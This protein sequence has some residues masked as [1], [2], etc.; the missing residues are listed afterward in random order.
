VKTVCFALSLI[1]GLAFASSALAQ[2]TKKDADLA[3]LQEAYRGQVSKIEA[4]YAA[5][6]EKIPADYT[7]ALNALE[8]SFTKKGDLD[9]IVAIRAERDRFLVAQ[10]VP[11]EALVKSPPAL[12]AL[13]DRFQ[14]AVVDL[15][16]GKKKDIVAI[17]VPYLTRL[18]Q[19]KTSLTKRSKVD[20]ALLVKTEID[21][22]KGSVDFSVTKE[23]SPG[24]NQP[25][26]SKKGETP[27]FPASLRNGLVLY[28]SF[29]KDEGGKVTDKSGKGNDGRVVGAKWTEKGK[30]D[31][32]Y[33]FQP[34]DGE[35][36]IEVRNDTSLSPPVAMTMAAWVLINEFPGV[37]DAGWVITKWENSR[38]DKALSI[39]GKKKAVFGLFGLSPNPI[40]SSLDLRTHQWYHLV[41][42]YDGK[43]LRL[44]INGNLTKE[45]DV[46]G[47]MRSSNGSLFI[48]SNHDRRDFGSEINGL[49]DEV[50]IWDRAL[51]EKEVEQL[52]KTTGE[53]FRIPTKDK[54]KQTK[55]Y[56]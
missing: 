36:Y 18:E 3:S 33:E 5:L 46:T 21:N 28:Y 15:E 52:F 51:S 32:A 48:G 14:K 53:E 12:K 1:V 29:D 27:I 22:I 23:V 17:T 13:Q 41:G 24:A 8:L 25:P 10:D 42:V 11:N 45:A 30:V 43:K 9:S 47:A 50:M 2:E 6:K 38:E 54:S 56:D 26:A 55:S 4:K 44:F 37:S 20:D 19:L 34:K 7:N 16:A 39:N 40:D 31:G 49:I 35:G